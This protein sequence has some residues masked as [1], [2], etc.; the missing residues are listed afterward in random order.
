MSENNNSIADRIQVVNT[1]DERQRRKE[2]SDAAFQ[3]QMRE[4]FADRSNLQ[5][6]ARSVLDLPQQ[7]KVEPYNDGWGN[8][9]E[10]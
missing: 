6:L 5:K 1:R 2:Q 4:L 10:G 3:S 9:S 7:D 8:V